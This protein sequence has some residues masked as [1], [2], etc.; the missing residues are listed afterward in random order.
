MYDE[1]IEVLVNE[2]EEVLERVSSVEENLK[3][4]GKKFVV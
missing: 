3:G 1:K 4:F 2:L